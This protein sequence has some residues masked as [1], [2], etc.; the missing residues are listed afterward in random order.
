ML[1]PGRRL[2][3][4]ALA[5]AFLTAPLVACGD[6][7]S[8]PPAAD[9]AP[10]DAVVGDA[11]GPD[12]MPPTPRVEIAPPLAAPWIAA[13]GE[14]HYELT[15]AGV[16]ITRAELYIDGVL[17]HVD[18]PPVFVGP[19]Y[20][21]VWQSPVLAGP[22]DF[23]LVVS[24]PAAP[25]AE[26]TIHLQADVSA[27]RI[28][29]IGTSVVDGKEV[30]HFDVRDD[31][32]GVDEVELQTGS[33]GAVILH[34]PPYDLVVPDCAQ[35]QVV[36]HAKDRVGGA[37]DLYQTVRV[38]R[39]C[40]DDCDGH[41]AATAAC[42]GDDCNDQDATIHPGAADDLGDLIDQSCD[43]S[44][45]ID[46]D[47]DGVPSVASGGLDCDD[48][49]AAVHPAWWRWTA[50]IAAPRAELAFPGVPFAA[51]ATLGDELR[52]AWLDGGGLEYVERDAA[53]HFAV[54]V[55]VDAEGYDL[56]QGEGGVRLAIGADGVTSIAY[57][58]TENRVLR[59]ATQVGGSFVTSLLMPA[60]EA[61]FN[62]VVRALRVDA[63]G[64][65]HVLASQ[66]SN[67]TGRAF[68]DATGT[69]ADQLTTLQN[70]RIADLFVRADGVPRL[71][72][73]ADN[74]GAP[75]E[76]GLVR[77]TPSGLALDSVLASGA[78]DHHAAATQDA[79]GR[80]TV[81][82]GDASGA[83][84]LVSEGA[85]AIDLAGVS[86]RPVALRAAPGGGFQLFVADPFQGVVDELLVDAGG[87]VVRVARAVPGLAFTLDA[88]VALDAHGDPHIAFVG[89]SVF[90]A[91]VDRRIDAAPD[92]AGD[93]VDSDC[94]GSP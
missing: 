92:T 34:A 79:T 70:D 31:E 78:F 56:Q 26:D 54:P 85:A 66:G 44:D 59:I 55:Q 30:A 40:D 52:L 90:H 6:D 67:G 2:H 64:H 17:D 63:A 39:A 50:E 43:G 41:A 14:L 7:G 82:Y 42:G 25:L 72:C 5:L 86:G 36:V 65:R 33:G 58:A 9:A 1:L 47:A 3:R 8:T 73:F 21:T 4:S 19:F 83:L 51:I 80:V 57:A 87:A 91:F 75:S 28:E 60:T 18:E 24:G 20:S 35:T 29:L 77:L 37:V 74:F 76:L 61:F 32:S 45:G 88:A 16:V 13:T 94:D 84:H 62:V 38:A 49:R 22:H 68:T 11:S 81:V 71:A 93:G 48:T 46:A 12:A 53:G 27:P 15:S 10:T 23:R 69:W 89:T